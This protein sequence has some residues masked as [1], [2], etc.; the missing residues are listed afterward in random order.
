[1][2]MGVNLNEHANPA[3]LEVLDFLVDDVETCENFVNL[4]GRI[5]EKLFKR[6]VDV[7][8]DKTTSYG[9][10]REIVCLVNSGAYFYLD[11][12]QS[13]F[14]PKFVKG[15]LMPRLEPGALKRLYGKFCEAHGMKKKHCLYSRDPGFLG[16]L[17][18]YALGAEEKYGFTLKKMNFSYCWSSENW[19]DFGRWCFEHE[20]KASNTIMQRLLR[21]IQNQR[22]QQEDCKRYVPLRKLKVN[23]EKYHPGI[24]CGL[25]EKVGIPILECSGCRQSTKKWRQTTFAYGS[26]YLTDMLLGKS[27]LVRKPETLDLKYLVNCGLRYL[28]KKR[29]KYQCP[30]KRP[31][32]LLFLFERLMTLTKQNLWRKKDKRWKIL[33]KAERKKELFETVKE[34]SYERLLE[35][36]TFLETKKPTA[37]RV[38][39]YAKLSLIV[40]YLNE[41]LEPRNHGNMTEIYELVKKDLEPSGHTQRVKKF[42]LTEFNVKNIF[43]LTT[44]K[45]K[46]RE[47]PLKRKRQR[48]L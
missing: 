47:I 11:F 16:F 43:G 24:P 41:N 28:F 13:L 29:T 46:R 7:K 48:K 1:M 18:G 20:K 33:S 44:R 9:N 17:T 14:F 19:H 31:I 3:M 8:I 34:L 15:E 35:F 40:N 23:V 39:P 38:L 12:Y 32:F 6:I 30:M 36:T 42:E 2:L 27:K 25:T 45:R 37:G 22:C 26:Y 21:S 4:T 10:A 5:K